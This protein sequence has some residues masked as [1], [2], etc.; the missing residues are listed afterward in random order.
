MSL[1]WDAAP[2]KGFPAIARLPWS[3]DPATA[4]IGAYELL[5]AESSITYSLAAW[6]GG[7]D[8]SQIDFIIEHS[9]ERPSHYKWLLGGNRRSYL[10]WL[11]Q[12]KSPEDFAETDGFAA[13]AHDHRLWFTSRVIS[14]ALHAT[15]YSAEVSGE[16]ASLKIMTQRRLSV[17]MVIQMKPEEI[18][19]IDRVE[20]K[21]ITLIIQGPAEHRFSTVFTFSDGSIMRKYDLDALYSCLVASLGKE[22]D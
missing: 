2:S 5:T 8:S 9:V 10:V 20:D 12:Y 11:H 4:H 22:G 1:F 6:L 13:S 15:W 7:L 17:G 3:T 14:G 19:K 21:T 18:H 16:T